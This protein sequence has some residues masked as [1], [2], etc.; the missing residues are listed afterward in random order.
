ME[1][2]DEGDD[3]SAAT[4]RTL[5]EK[6][7]AQLEKLKKET[8]FQ[9]RNKSSLLTA[10]AKYAESIELVTERIGKLTARGVERRAERAEK[11]TAIRE[12]L[13]KLEQ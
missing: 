12:E 1:C 4:L 2:L 8:P 6:D 5:L 9:K 7:K 11:F 3:D 13:D 10:R